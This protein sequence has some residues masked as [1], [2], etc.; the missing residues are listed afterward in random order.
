VSGQH[1]GGGTEAVVVARISGAVPVPGYAATVITVLFFGALNIL[2][3]GIVGTYA[4]RTFENTKA[5]PLSIVSAR[6][7]FRASPTHVA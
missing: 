7:E 5:R 4:W 2:G 3:L 6:Y 1:D